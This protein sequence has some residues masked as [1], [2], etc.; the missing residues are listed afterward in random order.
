VSPGD[1]RLLARATENAPSMFLLGLALI[2]GIAVVDVETGPGFRI[3]PLY[4]IPISLGAWVARR[5]GAAF[6]AIVASAV[7]GVSNWSWHEGEAHFATN[8]FTQLVAFGA[9]AALTASMRRNYDAAVH[10]SMVDALT[11][12]AN[13]RGFYE[14]FE[15]A[16]E[17]AQRRGDALSLVYI[18]LDDFKAVNDAHGHAEGDEVLKTL[19]KAMR[20]G[21]RKTDVA[22]RLGGDEFALVLTDGTRKATEKAVDRLRGRFGEICEARGWPVKLSMG[23][24]VLDP[25][26]REVRLVDLMREAD[27]LM[28]EAKGEGKDTVAIRERAVQRS[29]QMT[30]E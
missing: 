25:V 8:V 29:S 23:A 26:G 27:A 18:D 21:V 15:A 19:A 3:F 7:W 12:L 9:V 2:G 30:G 28:Y 5:T 1:R 17:L 4:F 20:E 24:L 11:G 14:R 6:F 22:A 16:L 13:T 10:T